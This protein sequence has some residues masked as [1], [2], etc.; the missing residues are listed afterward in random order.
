MAASQATRDTPL[1]LAF[2]DSGPE[3]SLVLQHPGHSALEDRGIF[4]PVPPSAQEFT[5]HTGDDQEF[6]APAFRSD[7][8]STRLS[9]QGSAL[10][11]QDLIPASP[12]APAIGTT[13]GIANA[14]AAT[15]TIATTVMDSTASHSET[16][17][18]SVIPTI[19]I[20]T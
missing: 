5:L 1:I 11:I 7:R 15:T 16:Q 4:T 13:T 2:P 10:P 9:A 17:G 3:A 6:S 19:P 12:I 20:P 14:T 18:G 8:E